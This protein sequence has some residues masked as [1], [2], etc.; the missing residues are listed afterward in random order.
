MLC[1]RV[2]GPI[3]VAA[4]TN[5]ALDQL[6]THIAAFEE[7]FVRLGSRCDKKNSTILARTLYELREEHK[8]S[9]TKQ[10]NGGVRSACKAHNNLIESIEL[11]LS[12]IIAFGIL[13]AGVL[14]ESGVMSQE[15]Y[16]SFFEPG[17]C[18]SADT[19]DE[20]VDPL[21]SCTYTRAQPC[22]LNSAY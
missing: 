4:Q 21:E 11:M 2:N 6:L 19:Q 5:H 16:D 15:H 7:K 22:L 13:P 3:I 1:N 20:S 12:P 9:K 10:F 8:K 18:D 14:L 17:W